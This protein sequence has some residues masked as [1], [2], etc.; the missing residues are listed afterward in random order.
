[1]A[2]YSKA[3]EKNLGDALV[4]LE[5]ERWDG[6]GYHAGFTVECTLS[7]LLEAAG[8]DPT[9]RDSHN[10]GRLEGSVNS[11]AAQRRGARKIAVTQT[12]ILQRAGLYRWSPMI[13][14]EA[15]GT[16]SQATA[17]TWV[18]AARSFFCSVK[19]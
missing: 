16:L 2:N 3:A 8:G 5:K 14:Y 10:L 1:M 9:S 19:P 13:R 4:L 6:A 7:A 15:A 11:L 12:Q 17:E 18:K